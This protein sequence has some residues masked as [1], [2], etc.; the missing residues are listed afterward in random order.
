MPPFLNRFEFW[1]FN[2]FCFCCNSTKGWRVI[3]LLLLKWGPNP[4]P[5]KRRNATNK[6]KID[7]SRCSQYYNLVFL[8]PFAIT[9]TSVPI[10]RLWQPLATWELAPWNSRR[11][12]KTLRERACILPSKKFLRDFDWK[13][14]IHLEYSA[15]LISCDKC[16][17]LYDVNIW[18]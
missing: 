11:K 15:S 10:S 13:T 14:K 8:A 18:I 2:W 9:A 6:H 3:Q 5:N 4:N 17:I 16:N 7:Q 12:Q 1:I